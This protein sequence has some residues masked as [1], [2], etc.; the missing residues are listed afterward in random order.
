M[1]PPR[2]AFL[3]PLLA[4]FFVPFAD[5][6]ATEGVAITQEVDAG[7]IA[8]AKLDDS[9]AVIAWTRNGRSVFFRLVGRDGAPVQAE[10]R[11]WSGGLA[12]FSLAP[13][14][15]ATLDGGFVLV[16]T[17]NDR[18]LYRR[19][20]REG[21][22][23]G[24][25]R[26]ASRACDVPHEPAV[27]SSPGLGFVITWIC[28]DDDAQ[29]PLYLRRFDSVGKP[30]GAEILVEEGYPF[31][32]ESQEGP[33]GARPAMTWSGEIRV[34]IDQ[35]G[36][37]GSF[38]DIRL[39]AYRNSLQ[40][41]GG[42]RILNAGNTFTADQSA[43]RLALVEPGDRSGLAIWVDS[44]T[45]RPDDGIRG[46][47]ARRLDPHGTPVGREIVL[48]RAD[49]AEWRGD[50]VRLDGLTAGTARYLAVWSHGGLRW[51]IV[52][53]NGLGPLHIESRE[54]LNGPR[55]VVLDDR[56][57]EAPVA[58]IAWA[59]YRDPGSVLMMQAFEIE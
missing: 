50:V 6:S 43:G 9:R 33:T 24:G 41:L 55:F 14:A 42:A 36:G 4:S 12:P 8:L 29:G 21:E 32:E 59:A 1:K 40:P 28:R 45:T 7:S 47:I 13:L 51:R 10:R 37:E 48:G 34:I 18:L 56:A 5:A 44:A 39:R 3:L 35:S 23:L 49:E 2:A 31:N 53:P 22:P 11:V 19:F 27:A 58:L 57:A 17:T 54:P 16:W 20:D 52:E 30:K 38:G 25:P 15:A 46:L 26:V